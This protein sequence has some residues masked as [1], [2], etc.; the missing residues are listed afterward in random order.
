MKA[1]LEG[2]YLGSTGCG[3]VK[4][5]TFLSVGYAEVAMSFEVGHIS[6]A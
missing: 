2:L 1:I 4:C 3:S 5:Y 6:G